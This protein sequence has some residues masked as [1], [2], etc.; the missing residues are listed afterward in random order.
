MKSAGRWG[1]D[2][3]PR[4][5][6]LDRGAEDDDDGSTGG[7]H[8]TTVESPVP[9]VDEAIPYY[10]ERG[11]KLV[12]R[13]KSLPQR[14]FSMR[15]HPHRLA[16]ERRSPQGVHFRDDVTAF[17]EIKEGRPPRTSV[18]KGG[19]REQR[20]FDIAPTGSASC[21]ASR[22][23]NRWHKVTGSRVTE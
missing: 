21:L 14:L 13:R 2:D 22:S 9:N 3:S 10:E 4:Q 20:V 19:G 18:D 16:G 1:M 15:Q 23:C 8:A 6:S 12:S 11:F 7:A 5:R 17:R